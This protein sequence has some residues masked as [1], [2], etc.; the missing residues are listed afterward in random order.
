[1]SKKILIIFT[2][3][4]LT[5]VFWWHY[6]VEPL[7]AVEPGKV[8]GAS[9]SASPVLASTTGILV[10][11][12]E[13]L[14]SNEEKDEIIKIDPDELKLAVASGAVLDATNNRLIFEKSAANVRS[15]GSITK[16]ITALIFIDNNPGWESGYVIKKEDLRQGG[17]IYLFPGDKVKLEDL[18]YLS[19]VGS[20]NTASVALAKSTG[21][22]VDEFVKL[23]NGKVKSLGFNHTSFTDPS[24]LANGNVS[25]AEELVKL[26]DLIL[27]NNEIKDAC[28]T[29]KYRFLTRQGKEIT[30]YNTDA[31]LS[32]YPKNGITLLGGKTGHIDAAGYCFIGKFSDSQGR[33]ITTA[34][35]GADTDNS[36]FEITRQLVSFIFD[37]MN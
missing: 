15:I 2:V 4:L 19:L 34:I 9:E 22:S 29:E 26:A 13:V 21:R 37:K 1:M 11:D 32:V 8:L 30:I 3:F 17:R 18:F 33:A 31:L 16:L 10:T 24:G 36:R 25:T 28:L 7:P 23:M 12:S 6:G 20:D 5:G 35:L 14:P 27:N